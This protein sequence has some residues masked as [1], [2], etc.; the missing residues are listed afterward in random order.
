M[1]GSAKGAGAIVEAALAAGERAGPNSM[2]TA[3]I[4]PISKRCGCLLL[5]V[6]DSDCSALDTLLGMADR[7]GLVVDLA[8][9]S[10]EVTRV[11]CLC[12]L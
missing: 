1:A 7:N 5:N 8:S 3:S 10:V 12:V 11:D 2:M 9:I 6:L 4:V